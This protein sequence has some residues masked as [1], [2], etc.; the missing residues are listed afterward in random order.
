MTSVPFLR[1]VCLVTLGLASCSSGSGATG[2]QG[3]DSGNVDAPDPSD[4]GATDGASEVGGDVPLP[5]VSAT[6]IALPGTPLGM[7]YNTGTKKAY[8][9][10]ATTDA[11]GVIR[12]AGIAIV[13]DKTGTVIRTIAV[14]NTVKAMGANGTTK[15]VYAA[16]GNTVDIIDSTTDAVTSV[17]LPKGATSGFE[18]I[19]SFAVDE[20]HNRVYVLGAPGGSTTAIVHVLDG[21]SDAFTA[22]FTV[23]IAPGGMNSIAVDPATQKIFVLGNDAAFNANIV[24]INGTNGTVAPAIVTAYGLA[25]TDGIVSV[26]DNNAAVTLLRSAS[27]PSIVRFIDPVDAVLPAGFVPGG[28]ATFGV[29][30]IIT[31]YDSTTGDSHLLLVDRGGVVS[32]MSDAATKDEFLRHKLVAGAIIAGDLAP[33]SSTFYVELYPDPVTGKPLGEAAV[34]RVVLTK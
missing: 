19:M 6:K 23:P 34:L 31:G 21:A 12:N 16:D 9:A 30:L 18:F 13:D 14:S 11:S 5:I 20:S 29:G 17:K 4:T 32:T 25:N 1:S 2:V 27:L 28:I 8:F 3:V 15:K 10:C 7:A 22:A 26:G 24:T 33:S